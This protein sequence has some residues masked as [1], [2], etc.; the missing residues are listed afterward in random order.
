MWP[1]SGCVC[2]AGRGWRDC[3]K[4]CTW[5]R[6]GVSEL[7]GVG[8]SSSSSRAW[9]GC[10]ERVPRMPCDGGE[11]TRGRGTG[12]GRLRGSDGCSWGEDDGGREGSEDGGGCGGLGGSGAARLLGL[13]GC[14]GSAVWT[15]VKQEEKRMMGKDKTTW[16]LREETKSTA[17]R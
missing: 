8:S 4:V 10:A 17:E 1:C 13:D 2:A 14:W 12:C 6:G 7:V 3:R 16:K 11:G 5:L 15:A 9:G